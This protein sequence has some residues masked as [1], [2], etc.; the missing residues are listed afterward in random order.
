MT[1]TWIVSLHTRSA[2][3]IADNT[4]ISILATPESTIPVSLVR[5]RNQIARTTGD[6]DGP[7]FAGALVAEAAGDFESADEAASVLGNLA[8]PY[9]QAAAVAAN[10]AVDDPQDML[11]FSPPGSDKNSGEFVVQRASHARFPAARI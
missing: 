3:R 4:I 11:I 2:V 8:S 1:K 7:K 10:A 5:I 6:P 9:F